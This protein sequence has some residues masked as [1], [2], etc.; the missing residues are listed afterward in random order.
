[1][2]K[3]KLPNVTLCCIGSQKY[4]EQQQKALDYSSRGIE[5]GAIKNIIVN[6]NTIDEWNKAVVFDLGDYIDTD[7]ALLIHPDG[8][9]GEP[10]LWRDEWLNYDFIGSP[11]PLPTDDF[12][13]RDINGKI[14]R[15]G[16]SVSLRSKK[17]LQLPKKIGMEWKPFHGYYNEDGY[18]SVNM[19]HVFEEHGCKF[20]PFEEAVL[21]GREAPL[22]ENKDLK[23]FVYHKTIGEN[24]CYPDFEKG[25]R[26]ITEMYSGQGLGNQLFCYV[27]TR[28]LALDKGYDFGT[29][30]PEKF[31]GS[32][33]L[34]LDFGCKVIGGKGP[35]GGPPTTLPEGITHY[36]NEQ[37]I[38]HPLNG[39]DIRLY[40]KNLVEVFPNTK[41]DGLMQDEKYFE[42]RKPEIKEWLMVK[43]EYECYDYSS[44]DI[45]II[46]FRGGEYARHTDLYLNKKYWEDAVQNMLKINKG[47][48]FVVITD[49]VFN[50]KKFF[51]DYD[52]FHFNIGKDY[53]V[54]KNAHYL[55][56]ANS[57]F[58]WFP[59][60]LSTTLKYCIAP[61]Y[62]ARH[63]VSDGYW[64]CGYNITKGWM[65]QDRDG[66]LSDY[67]TCVKEFDEYRATHPE[68]FNVKNNHIQQY[69]NKNILHIIKKKIGG[70]LS[71][72]TKNFI[73]RFIKI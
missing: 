41:I 17:L 23:T 58:S 69:E 60:W 54:V 16:N 48:K 11:F 59:A 61:K 35:E 31:K 39:S 43:E 62:W 73:A 68:Y 46:N 72:R 2:S 26:I 57:S 8:G 14:Q 49:D 36:Y 53:V 29:M 24:S 51:P 34:N 38:T 67:E 15:V 45:C 66:N 10:E 65:Y 33:F 21:F 70:M 52:V 32:E 9:I 1:M 7:F 13:Y 18:I 56:M 47:F 19:R 12:S 44:D 63:N 42:H 28:V 25:N 37:K 6:T 64:S 3:L 4:K 5:F 71:L 50:A 20:A 30:N 40:D 22:P 27:T 55:I